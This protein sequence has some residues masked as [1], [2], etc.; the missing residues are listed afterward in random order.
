MKDRSCALL[1]ASWWHI[2]TS[3]KEFY[4]NLCQQVI[5]TVQVQLITTYRRNLDP[6]ILIFKLFYSFLFFCLSLLCLFQF[7][8]L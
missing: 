6:F 3:K 1:T 8:L 5:L 7:F 2:P 4:S